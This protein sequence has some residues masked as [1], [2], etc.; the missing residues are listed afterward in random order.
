[1]PT[2]VGNYQLVKKIGEGGYGKIFLGH[3]VI[4][5]VP[6]QEVV[7]KQVKLPSNKQE[8]EMCLR[9]VWCGGHPFSLCVSVAPPPTSPTSPTFATT[10]LLTGCTSS[11]APRRRPVPF[12]KTKKKP[13]PSPFSFILF[14]HTALLAE[15]ET[16]VIRHPPP[17]ITTRTHTQNEPKTTTGRYP[18]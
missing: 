13:S 9:C 11:P 2:I 6:G 14:P 18:S 8:R 5:Y 16:H 12:N 7:L 15:C 4:G 17:S 10:L 1:M 3:P